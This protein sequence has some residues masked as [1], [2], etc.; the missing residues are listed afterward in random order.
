[1]LIDYTQPGPDPKLYWYHAS[2]LGHVGA[3]TDEQ[4]S[5]VELVRYGALGEAQILAP[6]GVTERTSS[7]IGNPYHFQGLW[8]DDE[9]STYH[10]R[11]RQYDPQSGEYLSPDPAGLWRHGQGNGYSAFGSDP[12]NRRDPWGLNPGD[13]LTWTSTNPSTG[14][15]IS[16]DTYDAGSSGHQGDV[17]EY[18][19]PPEESAGEIIEDLVRD[20][21]PV[22]PSLLEREYLMAAA[23]I[24][25]I[26]KIRKAPK[27]A[28]AAW[29][30]GGKGARWGWG[31]AKKFAC[32]VRGGKAAK[33]GGK[34]SKEVVT[35]KAPG[36]DG[37]T[38]R[39]I[40]EKLDGKTNSV[41]HQVTKDGKVI[42]Q[43][44]KH[45]G[46]NGGQRQFP[47]EW[48]EFPKIPGG[49]Q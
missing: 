12:W 10:N 13:E 4:G 5:V 47:D 19:S 7:V 11:H 37:A 21:F 43:H 14:Y 40:L 41:T 45:I 44:Q 26:S 48:V 24:I 42:H 46:T 39:H 8:W 15:M 9:T 29:K 33:G 38:S 27:V 36:A 18:E 23:D 6:D 25:P 34:W 2:D 17:W 35:R 30:L 49:G 16:V 28:K 3:L 20:L 31:K 1:M 22:L 32:W